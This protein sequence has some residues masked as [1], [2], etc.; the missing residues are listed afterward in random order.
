MFRVRFPRTA[1]TGMLFSRTTPKLSHPT[2][3]ISFLAKPPT[4]P[5][6]LRLARGFKVTYLKTSNLGTTKFIIQALTGIYCGMVVVTLALF[7]IL[8]KDANDRQFIPF[9]DTSFDDKVNSV[10]AI[11]KDEVCES[12][13]HAV[14]HYRRL[15]IDLAKQEYP[16]LKEEEFGNRYNVPLLSTD[17][18]IQNK[19]P[20]F[21]NFYVDMILRYCKCLLSKG[22]ADISIKLL[23]QVVNDDFLF[24]KV[25][26]AEK[27]SAS[28]R[29]L[30]KI[31]N[32]PERAIPILT[33]TI[34]MLTTNNR[35][36]RVDD[37]YVLEERSKVSDELVNCLNDLASNLAKLSKSPKTSKKQKNELL[38]KSLQIYMSELG[39]LQEMRT[40]IELGKTNQATYPLFNC[41][42]ANL[43]T[44][45]N[46]I[47]AHIS[48][49]MWA[50]G[51]KENAID[52]SE[53]ILN[54]LYLD[55][56]SDA[57]VG[58]ILLHVLSN[59]E[60]MYTNVKQPEDVE[61]VKQLKHDVRIYDVRNKFDNLSW[62]DKTLKRMSK[63]I[64]AKTPLGLV[65]RS[66]KGRFDPNQ[67][68]QELEEFEDEDDEGFFGAK[69]KS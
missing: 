63:V 30:A 55:R 3:S 5:R 32:D 27:L 62:Y 26:D 45:I 41:D 9:R 46:T 28:S 52:W 49:V 53:Q 59:L 22:E 67:K 50:K 57:R 65:E 19:T 47:K 17:F 40:S 43:V 42:R 11:N 10:L 1:P 8:Y 61:R 13:R 20:K 33:R 25:G 34:D 38:N 18:L 6:T 37:N 31:T 2:R 60:L 56:F 14:K 44:M 12:P 7:Y 39:S 48:E 69:Q 58:T 29:I 36:L 21:I 54:D 51:Y 24:N 16:D 64:Y 35:S 15:L 68:I 66:L 4:P 23:S